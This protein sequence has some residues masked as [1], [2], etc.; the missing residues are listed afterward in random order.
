[1]ADR[2]DGGTGFSSS[3]PSSASASYYPATSTQA[4]GA[5]VA[6]GKWYLMRVGVQDTNASHLGNL[7]MSMGVFRDVSAL[8]RC[9]PPR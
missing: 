1:V 2:P 8:L 4:N 5:P 6:K 9:P 3:C 7:G